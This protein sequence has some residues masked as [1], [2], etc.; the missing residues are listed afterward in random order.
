MGKARIDTLV[1]EV[2]HLTAEKVGLETSLQS[3]N[4]TID[5]LGVNL[6]NTHLEHQ[7]LAMVANH[8]LT[9]AENTFRGVGLANPYLSGVYG[10]NVYTSGLYTGASPSRFVGTQPVT[11]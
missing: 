11:K 7:R 1:Q 10:A 5:D 3:K 2:Q 8:N 6:N 4:A 9:L